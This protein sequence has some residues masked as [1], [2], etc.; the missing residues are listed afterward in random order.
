MIRRT[1]TAILLLSAIL[2]QP[3]PA[4][5]Q[6][7]EGKG[8]EARGN[9][10]NGNS[11]TSASED[12]DAPAIPDAGEDEEAPATEAVTPP[13]PAE[14]DA[15]LSQSDVLAAVESG[16]AIPLET[17]LPDV[18]TRTGGEVIDAKLQRSQGALLYAVTV[19]TPAGKVIREYYYARS[20]LHL[21]DR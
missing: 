16:S 10:G 2:S 18:R 4:W 9:Q 14:P 17:L 5:A 13:P 7:N 20:G 21:E 19:L 1:A 3:F 15:E 11:D 8:N 12:P 6:G